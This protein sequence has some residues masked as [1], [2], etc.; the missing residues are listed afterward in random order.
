MA[1]LAKNRKNKYDR[2]FKIVFNNKYNN[3]ANQY[4]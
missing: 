1:N 3:L 4:I 2:M